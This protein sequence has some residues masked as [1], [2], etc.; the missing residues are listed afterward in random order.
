MSVSRVDVRRLKKGLF[1][2]RPVGLLSFGG[3]T[4]MPS[5]ESKLELAMRVNAG[6]RRACLALKA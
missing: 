4:G 3:M 6:L 5:I 2:A 1:W